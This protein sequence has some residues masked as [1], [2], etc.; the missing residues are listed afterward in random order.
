MLIISAIS[1][2]YY[3]MILAWSLYYMFASWQSQVPWYDCKNSWNT[4]CKSIRKS[5]HRES[6][7]DP[8]KKFHGFRFP[9]ISIDCGRIFCL[10]NMNGLIG[11]GLN[12]ENHPQIRPHDRPVHVLS[13]LLNSLSSCSRSERANFLSSL[14]YAC[15]SA[16][17]LRA[18]RELL[19]LPL[20]CIYCSRLI[21]FAHIIIIT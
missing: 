17:S 21:L 11:G 7:D 9:E 14:K 13:L 10:Y 12:P 19:F 8:E 3:N 15:P 2:I 18:T 1:S 4:P 6:W 5:I 20:N 16:L